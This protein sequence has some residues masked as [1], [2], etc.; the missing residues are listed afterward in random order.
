MPEALNMKTAATIF[1]PKYEIQW[2]GVQPEANPL[3]LVNGNVVERYNY[4]AVGN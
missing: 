2:T 4:D 1:A 3:T